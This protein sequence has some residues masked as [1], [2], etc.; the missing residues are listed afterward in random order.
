MKWCNYDRSLRGRN[1]ST[2]V[3]EIKVPVGR[4]SVLS[5]VSRLKRERGRD[6]ERE[7]EREREGERERENSWCPRTFILA[8]LLPRTESFAPPGVYEHVCAFMIRI[9]NAAKLYSVGE[10]SGERGG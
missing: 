4:T 1:A 2:Y 8:L 6:R 10:I 5:R 9:G 7:R 3:A